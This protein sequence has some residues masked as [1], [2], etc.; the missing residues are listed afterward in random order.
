MASVLFIETQALISASFKS[1]LESL[2]FT[3]TST[4]EPQSGM[5]NAL[6]DEP[7]IVVL[8]VDLA[9]MC[10]LDLL[11]QIRQRSM[12]PV[13]MYATGT[14][15]SERVLALELGADDYIDQ[16]CPPRELAARLRAILRRM[17]LQEPNAAQHWKYGPLELW[18][19][20]RLAH[21]HGEPLV[22][23]GAEFNLLNLLV[24]NA[25][26]VVSKRYLCEQ[27]MG[28]VLVRHDRSID[29]HLSSI[30]QKLGRR[31]DGRWWIETVRG[32]GY[33]LLQT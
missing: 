26:Q 33:Q 24:R 6:H 13:V 14:N 16:H 8:S 20:K 3:V 19:G 29:V 31:D 18:S 23:T 17:Q 27:G 32:I 28:R 1:Y 21:W 15:E 11:R 9:G 2:E 30:R 4:R 10:G 25:G 5:E 7:S 22:L 12:V